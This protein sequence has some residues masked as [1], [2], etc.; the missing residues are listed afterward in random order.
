MSCDMM[1]SFNRFTFLDGIEDRIIYYLISP[2][3]KSKE[4]LELVHTLWKILFY[5]KKSCLNELLPNYKE[6]IIPLIY[7]GNTEF[8]GGISS[9]Q[10]NKKIFRSL[11]Q[12]EAW[13]NESSLIRVYVDSIE[14]VNDYIA[15]INIGID[16]IAHNR[17]MDIDAEESDRNLIEILPDGTRINVTTKNRLTVM[18]RCI[19]ALLNGANVQ[20]VGMLRYNQKLSSMCQSR[21]SL[22]NLRSFGGYKTIFS[23]Q[24]SGVS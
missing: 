18:L 21:Y 24:V 23:T 15:T 4:E 6:D 17:I 1:Q 5:D 10:N 7:E 12:E 20:G 16:T 3:N 9:K 22:W 2:I 19:L 13:A 11:N 14:P 8:D